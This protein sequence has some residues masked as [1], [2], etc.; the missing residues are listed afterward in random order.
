MRI[1]RVKLTHDGAVA[2]IDGNRL[3]ASVEIEKRHNAPRHS[4][5][6]DLEIIDETLGMVGLDLSDIDVLAFDG[7]RKTNKSKTWGGQEV[8]IE[9]AP[10]RRWLANDDPLLSKRA[11][12]S[13]VP[14]VSFPHYSGHSLAAYC[15]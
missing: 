9:L 10:Y 2:V 13:D 4:R 8:C 1:C 5:I 11:C 6:E 7:W 15:T 3:I 12:V 14:Y